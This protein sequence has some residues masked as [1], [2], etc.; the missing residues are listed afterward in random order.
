MV[1]PTDTKKELCESL[2]FR[3]AKKKGVKN[4]RFEFLTAVTTGASVL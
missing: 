1:P 2:E 3:K 4:M